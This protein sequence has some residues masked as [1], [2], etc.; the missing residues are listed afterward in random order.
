MLLFNILLRNHLQAMTA[1]SVELMDIT[2]DWVSSIVMLCQAFTAASEIHAQSGWYQEIDLAISEYSTFLP[3]KSP[4][5]LFLYVLGHHPFV[6]WRFRC[7]CQ[8]L[9]WPGLHLVVNPLYLFLWSLLL[10]VDVDSDTSTSWRVFF[11]WLDVVKDFLYRGEDSP[12]I[13]HCCPPWTSRPFHVA[14]LA[15]AF[16]FL[17]QNEPNCWFGHS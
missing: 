4:E 3:S 16:F 12:I 15:S 13:H 5:L 1:L 8:S 9:I 6:L 14:E 11:T 17:S 10:I 2:W 7:F